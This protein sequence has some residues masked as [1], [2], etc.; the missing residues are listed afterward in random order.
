MIARQ[1]HRLG[2]PLCNPPVPVCALEYELDV[3]R[4][5]RVGQSR[6]ES[7]VERALHAC[8]PGG[9]ASDGGRGKDAGSR[10]DRAGTGPSHAL[11][12]M[13]SGGGG[14][15]RMYLQCTYLGI[16][17]DTTCTRPR[18]RDEWLAG[19]DGW[20]DLCPFLPWQ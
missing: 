20:L 15:T 2:R 6:A 7:S 19:V 11:G 12:Q 1:V 9:G 10:P 8:G 13:G 4:G 14:E 17:I 16:Y 18:G 3:V 5:S